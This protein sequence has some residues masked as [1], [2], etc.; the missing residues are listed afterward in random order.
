MFSILRCINFTLLFIGVV[1]ASPAQQSNYP[2][3]AV[4]ELFTSQG[5]INAL[6]A[7]RLLRDIIADAEKNNKPI[8]CISEH[9]DFWNRFGWKDPFS[10]F[11]YT[12]RLQNY[13]AVFGDKETYTPRI[14]INGKSLGNQA[15]D[16]TVSSIIHTEINKE[17]QFQLTFNYEVF[18]DTLDFTFD[19]NKPL[20]SSK[21]G[22]EYYINIV[23]VDK[24]ITT[25][26]T[27]GDNA[28]KT[29][30][31]GNVAR[32]FHTTDLR[33]EKGLIRVPL[34]KIRPGENRKIISFIQHKKS[35]KIAGALA[36]PFR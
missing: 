29:L 7:D 32:F 34:Q 15:N 33:S 36:L 28:G 9:V 14:I 6:P 27:K 2:G 13:S 26:V 22:S 10:S 8:Y 24:S 1:Y 20:A 16:K 25:N 12:N 11:R 17:P 31:N 4:V 5:D 21:A 35:R 18:D 19:I 23:I 3:F 30:V